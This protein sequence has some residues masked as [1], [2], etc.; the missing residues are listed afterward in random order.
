MMVGFLASRT[1]RWTR[2]LA[3]ASLV[4]GGLSTDSVKGKMLALVGL[5]PLLAGAFDVCLF[6]PFFGLPMKG[7]AIRR[8]VGLI[9]EDSLL[10]HPPMPMTERPTLLH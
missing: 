6:G 8:K 3:G 1:G 2:M 7:E 5:V 9:G 10:P 4:V